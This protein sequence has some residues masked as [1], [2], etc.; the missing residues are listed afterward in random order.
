MQGGVTPAINAKVR[1][2]LR[3]SQGRDVSQ[4]VAAVKLPSCDLTQYLS[5]L[6]FKAS[7]I[8]LTPPQTSNPPIFLPLFVH[9]P[10]P[11]FIYLP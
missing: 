7:H 6:S 2:V 3:R 9:L 5:G 8:F 1:C 4:N 10:L 11:R